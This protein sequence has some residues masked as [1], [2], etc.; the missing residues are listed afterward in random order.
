MKH[1]NMEV[2]SDKPNGYIQFAAWIILAETLV[3]CFCSF[4]IHIVFVL[5]GRLT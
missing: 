4:K 2:F 3:E 1:Q 5:S